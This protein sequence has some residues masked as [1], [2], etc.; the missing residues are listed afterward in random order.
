MPTHKKDFDGAGA[1]QYTSSY[2]NAQV[3]NLSH[4]HL[5][6]TAYTSEPVEQAEKAERVAQSV[7]P[8]VHSAYLADDG[9][10][11]MDVWS[12]QRLL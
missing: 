2:K 3:I 5:K 6:I 8:Q 10:D 9:V 11:I 4:V 12:G 1:N 7:P